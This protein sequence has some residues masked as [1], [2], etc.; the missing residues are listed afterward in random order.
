MK[1]QTELKFE[2]I[3][4]CGFHEILKPLGFLKKS[5]NFYCKNQEIGQIIN[6]QKSTLYSR[7][8]IE[9]TINIG[10]FLPEYWLGLTYNRDKN[11][12][13]YPSETDCIIRKRIGELANQLDTWYDIEEKTDEIALINEMRSNINLRILPF[14]E[15][16]KTK[17]SL[18]KFLDTEKLDLAPFGKLI[19]YSELLQFERAKKEY[20]N[21]L[22]NSTNTDFLLTLEEYGEKYGI[23]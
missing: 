22:K 4:K 20:E 16:I 5:N 12:P 1:S 21:I 18:L 17:E 10:L 6:I 7:D 11:L 2:K 8:K 14:F 3:L 9:F 13:I 15:K 23:I 19:V